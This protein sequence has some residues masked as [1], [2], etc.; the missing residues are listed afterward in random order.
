MFAVTLFATPLVTEL[1]S[2]NSGKSDTVLLPPLS[3]TTVFTI[4]SFGEISSFVMVHVLMSPG[5]R[6]ILPD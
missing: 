3:L 5:A 6:V 2:M 4:V 1:P